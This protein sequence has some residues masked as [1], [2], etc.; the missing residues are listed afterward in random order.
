MGGAQTSHFARIARTHLVLAR[1]SNLPTVWSNCAAAWAI[2][3]GEFNARFV[4][5]ALAISLIYIGGMYMN[6]AFDAQWDAEHKANRPIVRGEIA[7]QTVA[8]CSYSLLAGG[9]VLLAFQG[10]HASLWG[11]GLVALVIAYNQLHKRISWS[12]FIVAACRLLVYVTVAAAFW[13]GSQTQPVI[14]GLALAGYVTGLSYVAKGEE[15]NVLLRATP[16]ALLLAPAIL[17][18][19]SGFSPECILLS[20]VFLV[21]LGYCLNF[22]FFPQRRNF[23]RAVGGMLA[24]ICLADV[25]AVSQMH[26]PLPHQLVGFGLFLLSLVFQRFIPAT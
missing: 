10:L 25:L 4:L 17:N 14:W 12:P 20:A 9:F 24:G 16:L 23:R 5:V 3:G 8:R 13:E 21:W 11:A 26:D 19:A 1:A 7:Q 22:V 6:D 15:R 18:L 2:A